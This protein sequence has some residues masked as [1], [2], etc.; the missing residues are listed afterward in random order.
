[1]IIASFKPV[2]QL[3]QLVE[4]YKE[5]YCCSTLD[6]AY[7]LRIIED[8]L[9]DAAKPHVQFQMVK[10]FLEVISTKDPALFHFD[11]ARL[12]LSKIAPEVLENDHAV[13]MLAREFLKKCALLH[14]MIKWPPGILHFLKSCEEDAE[15]VAGYASCFQ[16]ATFPKAEESF[17]KQFFVEGHTLWDQ[18]YLEM[19]KTIGKNGREITKTISKNLQNQLD[20][21]FWFCTPDP[22]LGVQYFHSP[23][24]IGLA[25]ILWEDIC[26]LSI[27]KHKHTV[28]ALTKSIITTTIQPLMSKE[29]EI[30]TI[31]EKKT[32]ECYESKGS[33]LCTVACVDP[34][35]MKQI[36]KGIKFFPSI[37]GQRLLRWQ[38]NTGYQ[39]WKNN[40]ENPALIC[41]HGGYRG[42]AQAIG[43]NPQ[44]NPEVIGQV[45]AI[46][47]VEAFCKFTFPDGS[48][49]NLIGIREI[50]KHKNGEP[51]KINIT[52]GDVLLPNYGQLLAKGDPRRLIP[53]PAELPPLIGSRNTHSAQGML[54]LLILNEFS[55]QSKRL[56]ENGSV[57]IPL[58]KWEEFARQVKLPLK[59][60][61][62]VIKEWTN[63]DIHTTAFLEQ[64]GD[65]YILTP[66]FASVNDFFTYQGKQRAL[67]SIAGKKSSENKKLKIKNGYKAKSQR[68]SKVR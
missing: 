49:G 34:E 14:R 60:L 55:H 8:N 2:Q 46:L 32:V 26:K 10:R 51:S 15:K 22:T 47:Q 68:K 13:D 23:A 42:I 37:T 45:R 29:L 27:E 50:E 3:S 59:C 48:T 57:Y 28:A 16:I 44:N 24:F 41:T 40:C 19:L 62:E 65:E 61:P 11:I 31:H 39:N 64:Q 56:V 7:R 53:I 43:A 38:V 21:A 20:L 63:E 30:K 67:G 52:L 54:Q 12:T 25:E 35:F 33:L 5:S 36:C 9:N 17:E 6:I 1:M 66:A 4:S 58:D 18:A